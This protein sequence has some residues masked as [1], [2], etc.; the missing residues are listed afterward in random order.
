MADAK[1]KTVIDDMPGRTIVGT[2]TE[3]A[4]T[5]ARYMNEY[6]DFNSYDL[7][8]PGLGQ[9][10][11]G[12]LVFDPAIYTADMRV[13]IAT[14]EKRIS[15][16]NSQIVAIVITPVP[17]VEAILAD[18]AGKLWLGKTVDTA[19]NAAAVRELRKKDAKATDPAILEAMPKTLADYVTSSRGGSSTL[20]EAY[21]SLWRDVKSVLGEMSKAFKLA[22]LSKKEFRRAMESKAHAERFYPMVENTKNGSV[23]EFAIKAFKTEAVDRGFDSSIFDR[24]LANRDTFEIDANDDDDGEELSLDSLSAAL[25]KK[26]DTPAAATD[27]PATEQPIG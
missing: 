26:I 4:A 6:A 24:W 3:A 25:A 8:A 19:L 23:F 16:G 1:V 12:A 15:Q 27:T 21:E 7:V 20:L 5:I 9:D 14:V 13:M 10:D 22:N 18:E 11:T 17:T 2:T